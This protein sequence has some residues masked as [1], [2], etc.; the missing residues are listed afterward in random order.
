MK[1]IVVAGIAVIS[2][3]VMVGSGQWPFPNSE[4]TDSGNPEHVIIGNSPVEGSSLIYIAE[5]QGYFAEN[6]LNVTIQDYDTGR[7]N[8]DGMK[9]GNADISVSSEYPIVTEA[10]KKENISVIG[11][12][13]KFQTH[14]FSAGK[15]GELKIFQT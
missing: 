2:A 14:I 15:T 4:T 8:V 12:I 1:K 3:L 9:K 6:G 13:D 7:A 10:F 5:D 11:I